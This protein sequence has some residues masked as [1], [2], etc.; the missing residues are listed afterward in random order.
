MIDEINEELSVS[1]DV[2]EAVDK[3]KRAIQ[4]ECRGF[5][6]VSSDYF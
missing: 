3:I 2:R 5:M 1:E 6:L 4:D